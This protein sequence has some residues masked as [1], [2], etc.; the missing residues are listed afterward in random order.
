M[1][2]GQITD[3]VIDTLEFD[4]NAGYEPDIIHVAGNVYAIAYRGPSNHGFVKTVQIMND[5][6]ITDTVID[7]LE[8]DTSYGFEPNIIHIGGNVFAIAYRGVDD[9]GF[10]KTLVIWNNGDI[11]DTVVDSFEYDT[12]NGYEPDI[13]NISNNI[14]AI[15]YSY[16]SVGGY[17]ATI[18]IADTGVITKSVIDSTRWDNRQPS[19]DDDCYNPHI[20]HISE[21]VYAIVYRGQ[22]DG[23]VKTLRIGNPGDISDVNDDYLMFDGEGYEP[24]IIHIDKDIYAIPFC[25]YGSNA[26]LKTVEIKC[27]PTTRTVVFKQGAYGLQANSTTVFGHINSRIISAP[28]P[29]GFSHIVLTYNRSLSSNQMKLY[30]NGVIQTEV[31]E[32]SSININGNNLI[33]GEYNCVLDEVT[34]WNIGIDEPT[35]L[36]NYNLFKP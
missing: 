10:V 16:Q 31:D 18:E 1:N 17:L 5:G 33:M 19:G 30:V 23:Y 7:T 27:I 22:F 29:S 3:T 12:N 9:D 25:G 6:Q 21:W 15:V 35:I 26:V 4:T 34:I 20:I 14:Y 32:S 24:Q 8:F 28:L 36:A 13:I 2:D 11:Q